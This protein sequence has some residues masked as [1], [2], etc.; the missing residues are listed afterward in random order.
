[1]QIASISLLPDFLTHG[2]RQKL[3]NFPVG[4]GARIDNGMNRRDNRHID[5][6]P[7]RQLVGDPDG[8]SAFHHTAPSS[9]AAAP[10]PAMTGAMAFGRVRG[11]APSTHC[12]KLATGVII[13]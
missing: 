7:E 3:C 8:G 5:V 11:R 4:C 12:A 13:A 9:Q 2:T 6:M 10:V 1:L